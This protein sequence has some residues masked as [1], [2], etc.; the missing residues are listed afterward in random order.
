VPPAAILGDHS[1]ILGYRVRR[2]SPDRLLLD[3]DYEY[4]GENGGTATLGV[5]YGNSWDRGLLSAPVMSWSD[6]FGP[7]RG[8]IRVGLTV[9]K[10][11]ESFTTGYLVFSI[12]AANRRLVYRWFPHQKHWSWLEVSVP[13]KPKSP[14]AKRR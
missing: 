2:Q 9:P 10:Q 4:V 5:G 12:Y 14:T 8:T 7:G 13:L 6:E 11:T 1:A 3:V